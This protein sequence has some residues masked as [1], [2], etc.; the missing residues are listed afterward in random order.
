MTTVNIAAYDCKCKYRTDNITQMH[1]DLNLLTAMDAVLEEGSVTGAADRLH[2]SQPAMSRT[3][4]RIRK[5]T[6]DQI[7]VRTGRTMTPT[8]YAL[9]IRDEVHLLVRRADALLRPQQRLDLATL[10]R[11][12]T[13][14]SHEALI[15]ALAAPLLSAVRAQAPG[16]LLRF[17]PE[18]PLD[19][20][21]LRQGRVDLELSGTEPNVPEVRHFGLSSG[22]LVVAMR[23]GH[24]LQARPLTAAT[25]A[26]ADHVIISRRG[27]TH[28]LIDEAL[29]QQ[30]LTRRV[31]AAV[32]S[33]FAALRIAAGSDA[34]T[35]VPGAA[36][37][38]VTQAF[39]LHVTPVPLA[40]PPLLA[41]C[42]WHQRFTTDLAHT[43]L[44]NL[45][46]SL[47]DDIVTAP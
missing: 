4:G 10:E 19:T 7:M 40:L 5:V 14:A 45:V 2:L 38:A 37:A 27:R 30:H 34:V 33:T 8:P 42:A 36:A 35:A 39:G 44:R 24:P 41:V 13:I 47:F 22:E 23:V 31:I 26:A 21:D 16:V 20:N 46:R 11:T 28:D 9:A 6:G 3:L 12:F 32:P 15:T 43:W 18:G 17:L 29:A 25:Y 1:L